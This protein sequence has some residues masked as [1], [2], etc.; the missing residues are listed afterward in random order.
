MLALRWVYMLGIEGFSRG[1]AER[2]SLR[3]PEVFGM[4]GKYVWWG[5]IAVGTV[6]GHCKRAVGA[7][8]CGYIAS[9]YNKRPIGVPLGM[10]VLNIE[11]LSRGRA[12]GASLRLPIVIGIDSDYWCRARVRVGSSLSSAARLST[13]MANSR[14]V[15]MPLV[16][17]S[18][19]MSISPPGVGATPC[20]VRC[21][22]A[23]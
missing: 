5:R 9:S 16:A 12:E 20:S 7:R 18:V 6:V 4:I 15:S 13:S 11:W 1:R 8:C 19:S 17:R 23:S 10:Y 22:S 14:I 21:M 3:L 2:A